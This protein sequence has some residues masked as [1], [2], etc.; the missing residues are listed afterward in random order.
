MYKGKKDE[1]K[2][3]DSET[4]IFTLKLAYTKIR[5]RIIRK[6]DD[7]FEHFWNIKALSPT[8]HF[9]FKLPS[10]S[11]VTHDNLSKRGVD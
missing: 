10:N 5:N 3:K 9:A 1:W 4:N 2:W 11:V 6:N 7:I 8:L